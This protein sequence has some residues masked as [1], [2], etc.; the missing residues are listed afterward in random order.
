MKLDANGQQIAELVIS[1]DV[2]SFPVDID[3]VTM[4]GSG[5]KY[6]MH[7]NQGSKYETWFA[8]GEDQS[9]TW[10]WRK[11]A[12]PQLK[13]DGVTVTEWPSWAEFVLIE[14]AGHADSPV[15]ERVNPFPEIDV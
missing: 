6:V 13:E 2:Y 4:D 1:P 15:K 9:D 12:V 7:F 14:I 8:E 3:Y 5:K 10:M 11:P